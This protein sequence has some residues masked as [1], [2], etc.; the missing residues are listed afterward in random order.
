MAETIWIEATTHIQIH[1]DGLAGG[2]L[3]L[4]LF[5]DLN[6]GMA[7]ES[8]QIRILDENHIRIKEISAQTG[9]DGR[10]ND[11]GLKLQPGAY[12][13]EAVFH[14]HDGYLDSKA[15]ISFTVK[16]CRCD[17]HLEP[18][19]HIW[20]VNHPVPFELSRSFDA[21]LNLDANWM[22]V[23]ESE[24]IR[25]HMDPGVSK[26]PGKF[27]FGEH[28]EG[29]VFIE[30]NLSESMSYYP[31][32]LNTSVYL[33][34]SLFDDVDAVSDSSAAW[35]KVK[36][37]HDD[38][39]FNGMPVTLQLK[40]ADKSL[41]FESV[42]YDGIVAFHLGDENDGCFTATVSRQDLW[43]EIGEISKDICVPEIRFSRRRIR[44]I[45]VGGF[46]LLAL[47]LSFWHLM[48]R[49]RKRLALPDPQKWAANQR[50][51]RVDKWPQ[52]I[53]DAHKN[54]PKICEI[55]CV[56]DE[57]GQV[58][59]PDLIEMR[60]D[61]DADKPCRISGWPFKL[62]KPA[63]LKLIH[64][65]YMTWHGTIKSYG[66]HILRLKTRRN[67]VIACFEVV[68]ANITGNT[69]KWGYKTPKAL[70]DDA[71]VQGML[72]QYPALEAYCHEVE[73]AVFDE[74][75]IDDETVEKIRLDSRIFSTKNKHK[76]A[77]N[78]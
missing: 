78:R 15:S 13:L 41:Q 44:W 56:D 5:N 12:L 65:N 20:P 49:T 17:G 19:S 59:A 57:T 52:G 18:E 68:C 39:S 3:N 25:I 47:L 51:T 70:Y 1:V 64:P 26:M 62:D 30:A 23:A 16:R 10:V 11:Y 66:R 28:E 50:Q 29:S 58:V 37:A 9:D 7:G 45:V 74:K 76:N 32:K 8:L 55:V 77:K 27:D 61:A 40:N 72:K 71:S 69:I 2:R 21:C 54:E 63:A 67:F 4:G 36:L 75:P 33:Y 60:L 22:V 53:E 6:Q 24:S 14:G 46:G 38:D 48:H 34:E 42:S 35:I 31:E 73:A 43:P